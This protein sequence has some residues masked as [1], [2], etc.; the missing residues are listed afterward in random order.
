MNVSL[1]KHAENWIEQLTYNSHTSFAEY[2]IVSLTWTKDIL[3]ISDL[4]LSFSKTFH[5]LKYIACLLFLGLLGVLHEHIF[6]PKG[7]A[8][9]YGS[10]F[11][12]NLAVCSHYV[13]R[14]EFAELG[15]GKILHLNRKDLI[16]KHHFGQ[17]SALYCRETISMKLMV[18]NSL[19]VITLWKFLNQN[20]IQYPVF[21][22]YENSG[23]FT[24]LMGRGKLPLLMSWDGGMRMVLTEKANDCGVQSW[25][26]PNAPCL[27]EGVPGEGWGPCPPQ[28]A[29]LT[30]SEMVPS[31]HTG[32]ENTGWA[33][34][35]R[36]SHLTAAS[37]PL[38]LCRRQPEQPTLHPGA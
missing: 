6:L 16:F 4:Q 10:F 34:T 11:N 5:S 37:K 35:P 7:I 20:F 38:C 29:Q 28:S 19:I 24:G 13:A 33:Q 12:W 22:Q 31:H 15:G 30:H 21:I 9:W 14:G 26:P 1:F 18:N 23:V 3:T 32:Q 36:G 8:L 2:K 17:D 27:S 25:A